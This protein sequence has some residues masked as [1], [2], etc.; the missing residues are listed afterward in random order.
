[1]DAVNEVRLTGRLVSCS[2]SDTKGGKPMA[3][4]LIEAPMPEWMHS[5]EMQQI[6]A[7]AF[8]RAVDECTALRE[9][10]DV[11]LLGRIQG[12]EYQGKHYVSL[13]VDRAK[14]LGSAPEAPQ[15]SQVQRKPETRRSATT[16]DRNGPPA[17]ANAV[18]DGAD[19]VPF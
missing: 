6:A 19:D 17:R 1:M 2:T 3:H 7:V 12:R 9:G 10:G 14:N 13:I 4:L 8:G 11:S 5:D 16:Q 15:P 18:A